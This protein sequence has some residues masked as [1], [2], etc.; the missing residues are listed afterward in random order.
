M[1]PRGTDAAEIE[2]RTLKLQLFKARKDHQEHIAIANLYYGHDPLTHK[3]KDARRKGFEL[4]GRRGGQRAYYKAI[5]KWNVSYAAAYEAKFLAE[6]IKLLDAR[7][8]AHNKA[9]AQANAKKPLRLGQ[10]L[11]LKPNA[12][13]RNRRA[14]PP[15]P[16]LNALLK[17]EH[18]LRGLPQQ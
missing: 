6:Q 17:N 11:K 7:L 12:W 14:R 15:K 8:T 13:L 2:L 4:V 16:R 10:R 5:S 18:G 9:I 1:V 3:F